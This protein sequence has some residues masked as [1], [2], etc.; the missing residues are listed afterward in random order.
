MAAHANTDKLVDALAAGPLGAKLRVPVLLVSNKGLADLQAE[1]IKNLVAEKVHQV[2]G[3]I[4]EPALNR[5]ID[6]VNAN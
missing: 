3:G 5:I 4:P 1:A 2:G 6:L